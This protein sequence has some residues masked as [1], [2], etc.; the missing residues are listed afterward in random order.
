[1]QTRFIAVISTLLLLAGC[2]SLGSRTTPAPV[3]EAGSKVDN[4]EQ[5]I[6]VAP[7][8]ATR[9]SPPKI[10]L[11]APAQS[12]SAVA[13]LRL[14]AKSQAK[15]GK[16]TIAAATLERALRI[17]PRDAMV[18]QQLAVVRLRQKRWKLALNIAAKSNALAGGQRPVQRNNWLIMAEAYRGLGQTG[19][20]EAALQRAR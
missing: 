14:S 15:A 10:A 20:A 7:V 8:P 4:P 2:G 11:A 19:K 9:I 6:T 12:G 5:R 3:E 18:W 1:M 13:K 16:Y 17:A